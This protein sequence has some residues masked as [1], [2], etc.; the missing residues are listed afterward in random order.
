M[1]TEAWVDRVTDMP[2]WQQWVCRM[3]DE[4]TFSSMIKWEGSV[5]CG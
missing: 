5:H 2:E 1:H 4:R 3:R